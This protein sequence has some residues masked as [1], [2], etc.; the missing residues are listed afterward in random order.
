M[1]WTM[2]R[3]RA[4]SPWH[5]GFRR[6]VRSIDCSRHSCS[7]V[8]LSIVTSVVSARTAVAE[9]GIVAAS[10]TTEAATATRRS[11]HALGFH[12]GV[13]ADSVRDDMM[14]PLGHS[15]GGFRFGLDYRGQVGPGLLIGHLEGGLRILSDVYGDLGL[16]VDWG[17]DLAWLGRL[18][19]GPPARVYLGPIFV[20]DSMMD[21]FVYWDDSHGYWLGSQWLGPSLRVVAPIGRRWRVEAT[22][23][24]SLIGAQGR[25][26]GERLVKQEAVTSPGWWLSQP[27]RREQFALPNEFE[28]VRL[29]LDF[30][31]APL[32]ASDATGG[33]TWSIDFR[34]RRSTVP[35]EIL[36]LGACVYA[37][38]M[39]GL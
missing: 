1:A 19:D 33:W 12:V 39:W 6:A 36:D 11:S 13:R 14:V 18:Y 23:A 5:S 28:A 20:F 25:P 34:M 2:L 16:G 3:G 8:L 17:F 22:A 24:V 32:D 10:P 29:A 37:S 7:I 30:R 9:E 31:R 15:G 21:F 4:M 27:A 26:P 38:R 35:A